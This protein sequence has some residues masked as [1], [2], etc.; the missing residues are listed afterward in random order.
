MQN[1]RPGSLFHEALD[2]PA[3]LE[4]D[5]ER[6]FEERLHRDRTIAASLSD[7]DPVGR[8]RHWWLAVRRETP[9][10]ARDTEFA[11]RLSRGRGIITFS[12]LLIGALAGAGAGM[13][14]FRYDGTWPVNVVTA[15]AALVLLQ[16]V[17]I[18]LT[19]ILMLPRVPG[20]GALQSLLGGLNPGALAAGLYRRV[21]RQDDQRTNL[22]VWHEARGPAA[23]HFAR[24]Q[25]LVWSQCAAVAFNIAVLVSALVLIAFTDLAFGW[26]TTLRLDD[27][28]VLRLTRLLAAPWRELWPAAVPS[29]ELIEHSR[30]FRLASAPPTATVASELTGWWP[31]LLAAIVTYGLLPRCCLL[32]FAAVRLRAATRNLLLDDPRVRALLDR[33]NAAEVQLGSAINEAATVFPD[34]QAQRPPATSGDA[35]VIVWSAA[36]PLR[37][38]GHW[39][40]RHLRWRVTEAMEAG[41]RTIAA[42][43]AVIERVA[44]LRPKAAIVY[45]R[46]WE[47]PLLDLQ[48]FIHALRAKVGPQCSLIVVPVGA[49]GEISTEAQRS[50]WSRWTARVGDPA[51][52]LESG[53]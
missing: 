31:F 52:Y 12:M 26:S 6:P 44:A 47:A 42:D 45:V 13:A 25:M 37:D 29:A 24:W 53:A 32:L 22:L 50:I 30:F 48:D 7:P 21:S 19:L 28:A 34:T 39:T 49:D 10:A 15:F 3:W 41:S 27:D 38:V 16:L 33:M 43:A 40:A 18:A 36:L 14:V 46:G 5:R 1:T 35:V 20:L 51:L 8:V 17:L 11:A 2:I 23:A 9:P 4:A